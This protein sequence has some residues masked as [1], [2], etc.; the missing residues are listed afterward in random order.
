M[1]V[2][3]FKKDHYGLGGWIKRDTR[4]QAQSHLKTRYQPNSQGE[5]ADELELRTLKKN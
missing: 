3:E 5:D 2:L 4:L 1:N